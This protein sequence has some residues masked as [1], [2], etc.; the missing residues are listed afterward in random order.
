VWGLVSPDDLPAVLAEIHDTSGQQ[1][2]IR[3]VSLE[4]GDYFGLWCPPLAVQPA[5]ER[6]Q[7]DE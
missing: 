4:Q 5:R 7:K 6:R 2:E 3:E 1:P